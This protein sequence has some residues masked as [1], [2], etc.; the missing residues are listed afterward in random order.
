MPSEPLTRCPRWR[1]RTS[2]FCTATRRLRHLGAYGPGPQPL[3]RGE[4]PLA[5]G[6]YSRCAA[7]N[8][9]HR[10]PTRCIDSRPSPAR[11]AS[12]RNSS[13]RAHP[14]APPATF[15]VLVSAAP[16][17]GPTI[18]CDRPSLPDRREPGRPKPKTGRDTFG[19][20][21]SGRSSSGCP[22]V[23][24][25]S[26]TQLRKRPRP[27]CSSAHWRT[28]PGRFAGTWKRAAVDTSVSGSAA[29]SRRR[30][31]PTQALGVSSSRK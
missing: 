10:S 15:R 8:A 31:C 16:A 2:S 20:G 17:R 5:A 28:A 18:T 24:A 12:S 6:G 13:H 30:S 22:L 25:W 29:L 14:R 19:V 21:P 3:P 27:V 4:R 11:P 23:A 7:A 9:R 26:A 1:S